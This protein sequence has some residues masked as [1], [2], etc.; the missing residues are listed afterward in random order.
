ME[1][2][3]GF[4]TGSG[5][6]RLVLW[7]KGYIFLSI[8][9][10][11]KTLFKYPYIKQTFDN[12]CVELLFGDGVYDPLLSGD[13][14]FTNNYIFRSTDGGVLMAFDLD[15]LNKRNLKAL[16]VIVKRL[17]YRAN[18]SPTFILDNKAKVRENSL[19]C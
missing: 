6:T 19:D 2:L 4:L 16:L 8:L 7:G 3:W 5:K 15:H 9:S 10:Y 11:G 18:S 17:P 13:Q 1:A 12:R 14:D